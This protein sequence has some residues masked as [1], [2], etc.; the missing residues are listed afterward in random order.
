[1]KPIL[2]LLASLSVLCGQ[3]CA[4]EAAWPSE[5]D[6]PYSASH[7][8]GPSFTEIQKQEQREAGLRMLTDLRSAYASGAGSF[9]MPPGDYRFGTGWKG[10]D[11]FLLENLDRDGKPPFRILG[12]GATLWFDLGP[13]SA[14]KVNYMLRLSGCSNIVLEGVILDSD[15]RGC[16][17]AKV[18]DFDVAGNRIQVEPLAGTQR[19]T[20]APARQNRFVPF[21]ANGHHIAALYNIDGGWGPRDLS[22]RAFST[23]PDGKFWFEM[24]TD[25]LLKTIRDPAWLAVYG[26]E[27]V[28]E[29]GDVLTFLWSVSFSIHLQNCKQIT[30]RD[31]KVFAAKSV[32]YETGYGGN[33]WINC[34]FMPRPRT[35]QL[36]GGEGRMS[37]ECMVG[38]LVDGAVHQRATDDAFMY[39]ALWRHALRVGSNSITFREDVP[40]LL[41]P[42]H[43]AELFHAKTKAYLGQLAVESVKDKRT[44]IFKQPV[45]ETYANSTAIFSDHMN[46]GWTVRNSFF[47]DCYQCMPLIQCGPGIFENN[48]IERAGAFVRIHNGEIGHIEGGLA[49]EVVFRANLFA[50]SF[51]CPPNPGFFVEGK[52][53]PLANLT[54]EGNLICRT[55]RSAVDI[56]HAR[57]VVLK[58]NIVIHPYEGRALRKEAKWVEL[59]AFALEHIQGAR[60]ENNLVIRR[61]VGAAI[62]SEKTCKDVIKSGNRM[63]TDSEGRLP[64]LV[65][66]LTSSHKHDARTIIEKVRAKAEALME[67]TEKPASKP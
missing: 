11:S 58:D 55:G 32:T 54:L 8:P 57:G 56:S 30:V 64:A 16:M 60:I 36:L 48:R 33:R 38:S 63:R 5:L 20:K 13:D 35:N 25:V 52:G 62:I 37:S 46:A 15:P 23:T 66:S 22:Y 42:G 51:L 45:G 10:A 6:I 1:M 49:D 39:R 50:D 26:P 67:A 18:T 41:A 4:K 9:T 61:D 31:C 2:I 47:L 34:R 29:K 24:E 12:H 28:I 14:P 3:V 40:A 43:R 7:P 65:R 27:G 59:P 21:K 44:V 17:D 19:L 53:R